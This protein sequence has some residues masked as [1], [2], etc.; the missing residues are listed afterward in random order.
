MANYNKKGDKMPKGVRF[1]P[2]DPRAG[3]PKDPPELK[4]I[5]K[6]T[7][8]DF[9]LLVNKS[10]QK[11][12][13]ELGAKANDPTA[14]VLDAAIASIAVH[15]IKQGD[16]N[17]LAFFLD[18]LHGKVPDKVEVKDYRNMTDEELLLET[19]N[20]ARELEEKLKKET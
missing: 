14:S 5:K 9:E 1:V 16:P 13:M 4:E 11:D 6:L 3:R 18:R 10:L 8:A 19:K 12:L 2:G 17:R 15:M 7:K 20:Y